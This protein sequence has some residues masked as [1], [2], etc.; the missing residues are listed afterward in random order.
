MEAMAVVGVSLCV[1][2]LVFLIFKMMKGRKFWGA[3]HA[4]IDEE[5][6]D[7]RKRAA[8]DGLKSD[9]RKNCRKRNPPVNHSESTWGNML[10]NKAD[11][12]DP[13]SALGKIFKLRFRIPYHVF[14]LLVAWTESW[15]WYSEANPEGVR[16]FDAAG[17]PAVPVELLVLGCLRILGRSYCLDGI[18]ELSGIST[19]KMEQ[20]FLY[21]VYK[22]ATT[23]KPEW[24]RRPT[25]TE[26]AGI[27]EIYAFLG[28]AGCIGSF[29]V[30]HIPWGMCAFGLRL[31]FT[32]KEGFPTLAFQVCVDHA[33]YIWHVCVGQ[34]GSLN[35]KTII[36]FDDYVSAIRDGSLFKDVFYYIL[37]S[38]GSQVVEVSKSV[39]YFICDG[40]YHKWKCT[41]SANQFD[42]TTE[43]QVYKSRLES[44]RKDV[45]DVFGV[46]KKMFGIL[47]IPINYHSQDTVNY[48]FVTCC[49][50]YNMVQRWKHE[51]TDMRVKEWVGDFRGFENLEGPDGEHWKVPVFQ[52]SP[53][54]K[55]SFREAQLDDDFSFRGV[56]HFKSNVQIVPLNEDIS[57]IDI[58]MLDRLSSYEPG[59]NEFRQELV[60][61]MSL[62]KKNQPNNV[63]PWV[64]S[65]NIPPERLS[66]A[67]GEAE[68]V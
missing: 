49:I 45:E 58:A 3:V 34:Y 24:L 52:A 64:R 7:D 39:L 67:G 55:K 30:V 36:R 12:L 44:V 63:L 35:D 56:A 51:D 31:I 11:L 15:Y 33:G 47:K 57:T 21:W 22:V 37:K 48:I 20:F 27:M 28:L 65:G 14:L 1:L 26:L 62:Y 59:F 60:D 50:L 29:D 46:L 19:A 18:T 6:E 32:G 25:T 42:S 54:D 9:G 2:V 61:H 5:E 8:A 53:D 16:K 23:L 17:V 4:A 41:M 40:G 68:A 66:V 43:G 13:Q 38:V 10:K